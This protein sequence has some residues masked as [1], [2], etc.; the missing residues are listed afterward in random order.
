MMDF[1]GV[2]LGVE[3]CRCMICGRDYAFLDGTFIPFKR[4]A[5]P[6]MPPPKYDRSRLKYKEI[7]VKA[8]Y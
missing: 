2:T 3:V 1:E 7:E 4:K 5:R 8:H 6:V